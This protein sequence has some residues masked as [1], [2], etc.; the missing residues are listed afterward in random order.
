MLQRDV[1][2]VSLNCSNFSRND[3]TFEVGV[4]GSCGRCGTGFGLLAVRIKFEL[5][6]MV[7]DDDNDLG[8]I[9]RL[10]E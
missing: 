6:T 2:D 4:V 8:D 9:D 7:S 5:I 1:L 3:I 10:D